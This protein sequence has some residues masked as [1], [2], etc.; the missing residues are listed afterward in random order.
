MSIV[1]TDS[2]VAVETI[3]LP[4]AAVEVVQV[5]DGGDVAPREVAVD[6]V[7]PR[8]HEVIL[9]DEDE[10]AAGT[11]ATVE[12]EI[13]GAI[14]RR[15]R[16]PR[17]QPDAPGPRNGQVVGE[18]AVAITTTPK[19]RLELRRQQKQRNESN[20]TTLLLRSSRRPLNIV[21]AKAVET[22]I[23]KR[24]I[25]VVMTVTAA[26]STTTDH[27]EIAVGLTDREVMDAVRIGNINHEK[28]DAGNQ[29]QRTTPTKQVPTVI[30]SS[31]Q[32]NPSIMRRPVKTKETLLREGPDPIETIVVRTVPA[33]HAAQKMKRDTHRQSCPLGG[34]EGIPTETIVPNEVTENGVA[35]L[36]QSAPEGMPTTAKM[37]TVWRNERRRVDVVRRESVVAV[38][39]R[40]TIHLV[41]LLAA[42]ETD[43]PS[44]HKMARQLRRI[45]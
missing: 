23:V 16:A 28:I 21:R 22:K 41:E 44:H 33:R 24:K 4:A 37:E 36:L 31:G 45:I 25:V 1:D 32:R 8:S 39:P 27:L 15:D 11:T 38:L 30:E 26:V 42:G 35:I 7:T 40:T 19:R 10:G 13:A 5:V 18:P 34:V 2:R 29:R 12:S 20:Q 43:L 14:A 17:S 9:E 6:V 3:L